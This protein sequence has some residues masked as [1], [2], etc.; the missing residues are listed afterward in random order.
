M[1]ACVWVCVCVCVCV[2]AFLFSHPGIYDSSSVN[3]C[4]ITET[5][6]TAISNYGHT[7]TRTAA[8]SH[9]QL[10]THTDR[11]TPPHT[12]YVGLPQAEEEHVLAASCPSFSHLLSSCHPSCMPPLAI[13]SF[14]WPVGSRMKPLPASSRHPLPLRPKDPGVCVPVS[15]S[16][17]SV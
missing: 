8:R 10:H 16:S 11:N 17:H 2:C 12:E 7:Y 4:P 9:R 6:A 5:A 3:C 13:L 15:S 1:Y 14:L